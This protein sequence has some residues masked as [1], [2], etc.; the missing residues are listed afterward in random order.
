MTL[1]GKIETYKG[2]DLLLQAAAQLPTTSKAMILI[3][4][5]C[6]D[7]IYRTELLRLAGDAGARV[8][9]VLERV[10]EE[11]VARYMQATD[12]A[13]FPFREVTNSASIMLAQSFSRPVIITDLPSLRDI[14]EDSA[15]RCEP[16][17]PA[18]VTALLEAEAL[19]TTQRQEMGDAGLAWSRRSNWSDIALSTVEAYKALRRR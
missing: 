18:L 6:A 1:L 2:A 7:R 3:V 16:N 15:I 5:S 14:P 12:V 19:S 13:V 17:V 8:M 9:T 10:S 4:G 11:D